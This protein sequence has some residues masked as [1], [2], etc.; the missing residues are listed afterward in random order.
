MARSA[1][2][3]YP[4]RPLHATPAGF[5]QGPFERSSAASSPERNNLD[6]ITYWKRRTVQ[7]N[8]VLTPDVQYDVT[9]LL[10]FFS[11]FLFILCIQKKIMHGN[12]WVK[13]TEATR[14]YPIPAYLR[15]FAAIRVAGR[16]ITIRV[17]LFDPRIGIYAKFWVG[18]DCFA[19]IWVNDAV[20]YRLRP[21]YP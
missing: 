3:Q 1:W 9:S 8:K 13:Y 14:S 5:G 6:F 4:T 15:V 12:F 2:Q 17:V 10:F 18:C 11:K 21:G 19:R 20:T 16:E 7:S